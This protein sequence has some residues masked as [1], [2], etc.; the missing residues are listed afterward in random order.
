[1]RLVRYVGSLSLALGLASAHARVHGTASPAEFWFLQEQIKDII[2]IATLKRDA[3]P[4]HEQL[5]VGAKVEL[6]SRNTSE[7]N[8]KHGELLEYVAEAQRWAVELS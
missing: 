6:H 5:E 8:G 2:I 3:P 1:V 7:H 4:P